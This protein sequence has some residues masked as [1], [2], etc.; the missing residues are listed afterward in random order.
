MTL[1]ELE[2]RIGEKGQS[3]L[4]SGKETVE[5]ARERLRRLTKGDVPTEAEVRAFEEE[6][7]RLNSA[8][9]SAK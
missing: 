2:D 5:E 9:S 8:E 4:I 7:E 3:C 1:E 6:T